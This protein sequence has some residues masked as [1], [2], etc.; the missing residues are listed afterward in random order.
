MPAPTHDVV[1][2]GSG[3]GGGAAAWALTRHGLSVLVLEAGPAFDPFSDYPL[4]SSDWE[5]H[6]FPE[7]EG[8]Q[9]RHTFAP[10]QTLEPRWENLRSWSRQSGPMVRGE[11]RRVHGYRHVR[12]VGGTTL[13]FTGEAHRLHPRAMKMHEAFGVAADWPFEYAD[14]EPYYCLAEKVV[15]VAGPAGDE[16]RPRS[17]PYPLPAHELS[18][19]SQQLAAGCRKLGLS[20]VAN[21]LAALSEPY[22]GRPACNYCGNCNRGCPR[23]DKGSVDVTFLRQ[24]LATGR[25]SLEPR[26][27]VTQIE[28][29]GDDRVAAVIYRDGTGNV[30]RT[31]AEVLILACGAVET[32][33]L[34]LASKSRHAPDGLANE[35]GLVGRHF[36]E[37]LSWA[38]SGLHPGPLGSHRGLPSDSICWDYNAP[39]AVPGEIGGCRFSSSVAEV[40][41]LGPINYAARVV[42]GWGRSHKRA[43]REVFGN[44]LSVGA[45]GE[46]LP[47]PESYVDLDPEETDASGVPLARIH[48]FL[49]EPELR[50]LDFM[51]RKSREIL[52]ASGVPQILEEYG[53]YDTFNATH[54][55]GT[56][57]MGIDPR[58]SVVD[59]H[60]GSHRWRNLFVMDASVFPS[61]GGGEAPSLTIEAVAIRS[62]DHLFDRMQRRE[63]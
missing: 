14:L 53:T 59:P 24:A 6:Q 45:I 11:R 16:Q 5:Q 13:H 23:T 61:S 1:V 8:S 46:S 40:D 25:C 17:E 19:A 12:G 32:P 62:A 4:S 38:S 15:G 3:A 48:S 21:S 63:V 27:L 44:V 47:N 31:P 2:V 30:Q 50:R 18:Y 9:G 39:D 29:G 55:F 26:C 41:L 36:M 43:M 57:R 35:E 54:V 33:R 49:P 22:D 20:W 56:C 37:T 52:K 58:D 7:K 28:A 10:M 51:A 42:S 34:L 60:S